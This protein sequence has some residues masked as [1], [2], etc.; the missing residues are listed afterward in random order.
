MTVLSLHS[1]LFPWLDL[2][3]LLRG[4]SVDTLVKVEIKYVS[5]SSLRR[6]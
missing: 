5:L 4:S 1:E 6:H 3:S 2:L